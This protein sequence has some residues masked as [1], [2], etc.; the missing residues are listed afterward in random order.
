MPRRN[1]IVKKNITLLPERDR[2]QPEDEP[3]PQ[4]DDTA[5]PKMAKAVGDPTP[6]SGAQDF[7]LDRLR[8]SQ[9]YVSKISVRRHMLNLPVKKPDKQAWIR[10]HRDE[11]Y[12]LQTNVIELKGERNETYLVDPALWEELSREL[13]PRLL[14]LAITR[15]MTP[16]IWP[17]RLSRGDGRPDAWSESA[18]DACRTAQEEWVRVVA[19]MD[20]GA[21]D[22][23][24]TGNVL[25][26]PEWPTQSFKDL[27]RLGFHGR[28]IVTL[29]HPIVRK[30][31]GQ[32]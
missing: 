32:E 9:D 25:A 29:D 27:L 23:I 22:V 8:L 16:F 12:R 4:I 30:L 6:P 20:L 1:H 26:E 5:T 11:A 18:L 17:L 3:D 19:N 31:R 7:D 13:T 14:V 21:Y 15:Q 28:Y 2:E 24:R 10:V